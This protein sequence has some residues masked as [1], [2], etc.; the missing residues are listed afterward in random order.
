MCRSRRY[1][2]ILATYLLGMSITIVNLKLAILIG[3]VVSFLWLM[4]HDEVS[5]QKITKRGN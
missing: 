4:N 2:V 3:V 1:A 5:Y